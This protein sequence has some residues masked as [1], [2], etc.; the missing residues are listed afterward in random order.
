MRKHKYKISSFLFKKI[1]LFLVYAIST[2]FE[3]QYLNFF[4]SL[5]KNKI[6]QLDHHIYKTSIFGGSKLAHSFGLHVCHRCAQFA[7]SPSHSMIWLESRGTSQPLPYYTDKTCCCSCRSLWKSKHVHLVSGPGELT[8]YQK[9]F[10]KK[11]LKLL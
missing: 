2:W 6:Y 9:T 1:F 5:N 11:H 8:K 4:L 3:Y 7:S 10:N